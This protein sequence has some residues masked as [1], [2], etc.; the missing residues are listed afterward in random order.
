MSSDEINLTADDTA[1]TGEIVREESSDMELAGSEKLSHVQGETRS[2]QRLYLL[3]WLLPF[4]FLTVSL[5]G[6]LRIAGIDR[7]LIFLKPSLFCLIAATILTVLFFRAGLIQMAGWFSEDFDL[8]TN[9][10]NAA[11]LVT[12]F[13]ASTQLFNSLLPESGLPL[14]IVGF[15]FFWTLW[16]NLFSNFDTKRL[17]RSLGALFGLAFVVKYIVLAN[18]TAPVSE[19]WIRSVLENP[20]Q[21]A[22]TSLLD[23]PR[24][25]AGTGYLQFFAIVFYLLGLFLLPPVTA[26][27]QHR[28]S[29]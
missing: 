12:L 2:K 22:A 5:L 18:L 7:S 4:V 3:Y 25:S 8:T 26:K 15:C 14:W 10:A 9:V 20:V 29:R 11:V 23:L 24:F 28:R 27:I 21:A 17:L 19:S 6:G 1:I 16:N 13:A